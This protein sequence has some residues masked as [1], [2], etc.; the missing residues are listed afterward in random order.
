MKG[1]EAVRQ[2]SLL[3]FAKK[4]GDVKPKKSSS[5]SQ[6]VENNASKKTTSKGT[7]KPLRAAEEDSG[8][9]VDHDR[10]D[11]AI[12][13]EAGPEPERSPSPLPLE[14]DDEGGALE[15]TQLDGDE[16]AEREGSPDWDIGAE[17]GEPED[18]EMTT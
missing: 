9:V 4:A 14:E 6:D 5:L 12:G 15:E 10:G 13:H 2:T 11:V 17:D 18:V 7:V 3:G 1:K 16:E 8:M